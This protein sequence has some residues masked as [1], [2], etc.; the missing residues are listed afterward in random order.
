MSTN[1]EGHIVT[2]GARK[3][4]DEDAAEAA[5]HFN[6]EILL[7]MYQIMFL[8]A[9]TIEGKSDAT[10]EEKDFSKRLFD[11]TDHLQSKKPAER[12]TLMEQ[13]M[14]LVHQAHQ[15]CKNGFRLLFK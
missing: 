12:I 15:F 14:N 13:N 8:A 10:K 7:P 9:S 3:L 5:Q 11:F 4:M 6:D 1:V 2:P